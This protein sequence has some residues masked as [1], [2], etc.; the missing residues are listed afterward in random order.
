MCGNCSSHQWN[1]RHDEAKYAQFFAD[2]SA[3]VKSVAP[4]ANCI[5]NRVPK[6]WY[7]KEIYCQLVPNE[8]DNNPYYDIIPRIGAFEVS[9][10]HDNIDILLYSK[11]MST[12]WPHAP[13]LA[14]RVN[15]FIEDSKKMNGSQLKEK[16][17]TTGRQARAPRESASS[18]AAHT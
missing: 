5:M 7:E 4:N 14:A 12:M 16:Y 11:M 6:A 9:I 13:S 17:Q 3:N 15:E 8:D 10:V 2:V 1:T 18:R